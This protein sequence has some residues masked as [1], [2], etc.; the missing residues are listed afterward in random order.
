MSAEIKD[1]EK[2]YFPIFKPGCNRLIASCEA[3]RVRCVGWVESFADSESVSG[4]RSE[5][6]FSERAA[7]LKK[8]VIA[9]EAYR[10]TLPIEL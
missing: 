3:E 4:R 2:M 8:V 10:A 5:V 7:A 6:A 9:L 1:I